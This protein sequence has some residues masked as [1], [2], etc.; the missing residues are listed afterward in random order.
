MRIVAKAM[1][2][3]DFFSK[4]KKQTNKKTFFNCQLIQ[5]GIILPKGLYNINNPLI[6]PSYAKVH[7]VRID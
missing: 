3:T 1:R 4:N 6:M 7:T 5:I 2:D